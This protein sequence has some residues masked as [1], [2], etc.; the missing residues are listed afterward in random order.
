MILEEYISRYFQNKSEDFIKDFIKDIF[1]KYCS[2]Y[3]VENSHNTLNF[4]VY[5][6]SCC[7]CIASLSTWNIVPHSRL[8]EELLQDN[9][10]EYIIHHKISNNLHIECICDIDTLTLKGCECNNEI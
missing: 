3:D 5:N 2:I 6:C 8:M 9:N 7:E 10:I 1:H 4:K